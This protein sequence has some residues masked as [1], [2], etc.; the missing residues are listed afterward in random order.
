MKSQ[1]HCQQVYGNVNNTAL[2]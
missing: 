2:Y 1:T